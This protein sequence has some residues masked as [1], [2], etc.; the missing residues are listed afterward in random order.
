MIKLKLIQFPLI[1][2]TFIIISL[3]F[4]SEFKVFFNHGE[5]NIESQILYVS[6]IVLI[7]VEG[8]VRSEKL[9]EDK[10]FSDKGGRKFHRW[11]KGGFLDKGEKVC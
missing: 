10:V 1:Q 7:F 11:G 9:M 5:G 3:L 4:S 6:R 8:P 2:F